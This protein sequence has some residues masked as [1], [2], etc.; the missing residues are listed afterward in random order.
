MVKTVKLISPN[1]RPTK[2]SSEVPAPNAPRDETILAPAE[3]IEG[4][5]TKIADLMAQGYTPEEAAMLA[6]GNIPEAGSDPNVPGYRSGPEVKAETDI[7]ITGIRIRH[8]EWLAR[9]AT[10]HGTT[11][12]RVVHKIIAEAFAKDP[13]KGGKALTKTGVDAVG[14]SVPRSML[15]QPESAE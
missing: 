8:A 11:V 6:T 10:I 12:D 2:P 7:Q 9:L 1:S 3:D 5:A 15:S 4:T 14:G 13:T